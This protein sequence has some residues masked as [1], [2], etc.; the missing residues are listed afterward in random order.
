MIFRSVAAGYGTPSGPQG[1][2][3][4]G[5]PPGPQGQQMAPPQ[6]GSNY[7]APPQQTGYGSYGKLSMDKT[8]LYFEHM[9]TYM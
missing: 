5:A 2:Q 1:Y 6:W 3:G 8:F 9:R 4:W 7:G